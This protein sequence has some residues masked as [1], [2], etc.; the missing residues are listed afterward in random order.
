MT[1]AIDKNYNVL[2][3]DQDAMACDLVKNTLGEHGHKVTICH[4]GHEAWELI[5]ATDRDL[6]ILD[7]DLPSVSGFDILSRCQLGPDFEK[8]PIIVLSDSPDDDVCDRALALGASAF[9]MKPLRLPLLSHA[10][11]QIL[12]NRARDREL[13]RFKALLGVEADRVAAFA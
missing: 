2:V 13:R 12:R 7:L 3:A 10:V 11:W 4:D 5:K 9:I 8:I 1:D 6:L